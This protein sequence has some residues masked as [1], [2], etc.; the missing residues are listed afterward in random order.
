LA[1]AFSNARLIAALEQLH[2][3][4]LNALARAIDAKSDW[5]AGHSER[6]TNLA[7]EIGRAMRLSDND[8]RIMHRGGLLHDVGKIGT[9]PSI[10]DKP[11]KLDPEEMRIMRDHVIV[12]VRILEPIAAFREVL[13]IVAQHHE[14]WDGSGYPA[15]LAGEDI[16]LYARIF[17]VADCYDA[18]TSDRPYREGLQPDHVLAMIRAGS[19]AQFDPRIV[20]IFMGLFA[21]NKE[22]PIEQ[23]R[24]AQAGQ[25]G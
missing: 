2:W 17:A 12:G 23:T 8:L 3:G 9:P 13:P 10:L 21:G 18:L 7:L 22:R 19:G 4:A 6:V 14:R 11:G 25:T 1:V 20:E 15:G 5:T 24:V 16:N